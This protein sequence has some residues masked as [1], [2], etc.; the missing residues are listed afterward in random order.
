MGGTSSAA[1]VATVGKHMQR[2]P[3][4]A[5]ARGVGNEKD[6]G[7]HGWAVCQTLWPRSCCTPQVKTAPL[8]A[9]PATQVSR[10][11][12]WRVQR[13]SSPA[14]KSVLPRRAALCRQTPPR[15][16][17]APRCPAR[18]QNAAWAVTG[19]PS[20]TLHRGRTAWATPGACGAQ[21]VICAGAAAPEVGA[22]AAG[23]ATPMRAS[24]AARQCSSAT[25]RAQGRLA[26]RTTRQTSRH[27]HHSSAARVPAVR[28]PVQRCAPALSGLQGSMTCRAASGTATLRQ[29]S[30]GLQAARAT[31]SAALATTIHRVFMQPLSAAARGQAE[32]SAPTRL[33]P[34][35]GC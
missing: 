35:A 28:P 23:T 32:L 12:R 14:K 10:E 24:V 26:W 4:S 21:I 20:G 16:T 22:L 17:R 15:G 8:H 18:A 5:W 31:A 9:E 3:R 13:S 6:A 27:R 33:H 34:F 19:V 11:G 25:R 2:A 1:G 30:A 29:F 7:A